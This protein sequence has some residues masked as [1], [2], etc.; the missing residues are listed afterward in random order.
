MNY[1]GIYGGTPV[2][3]TSRCDTCVHACVIRGYSENEKLTICEYPY[4]AF[5]VPFKVAECTNYAN[6]AL[7]PFDQMEKIAL[8]IEPKTRVP[9][10]GFAV[11]DLFEIKE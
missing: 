11:S 6:K 3:T 5:P 1:R 2:G 9:V 8:S 4:P 7:P 10:R